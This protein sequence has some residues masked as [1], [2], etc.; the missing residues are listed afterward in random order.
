MQM[1]IFSNDEPDVDRSTDKIQRVRL[2]RSAEHLVCGDLLERGYDAM[3]ASE[4]LSYD[5]VVD[6]GGLRR[7]QVKST[8]LRSRPVETSGRNYDYSVYRFKDKATGLRDKYLGSVDLLAFVA[9]DVRRI[10]Y[11]RPEFVQTELR[12]NASRLTA[13]YCELSWVEA[14]KE[15]L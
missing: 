10:I 14:V 3:I 5:V 7:I 4:G 9:M 11:A 8:V 12:I 1:Q 15:W 2:S 6:V 13:E